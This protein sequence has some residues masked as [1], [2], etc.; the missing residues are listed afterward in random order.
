MPDLKLTSLEILEELQR[1]CVLQE[2]NKVYLIFFLDQI[3]KFLP[4][5][6]CPGLFM[7]TA[8]SQLTL[9]GAWPGAE[10][11]DGFAET[12]AREGSN[13]TAVVCGIE[14]QG[15]GSKNFHGISGSSENFIFTLVHFSSSL[16]VP[17]FSSCHK[18]YLSPETK[19]G[20]RCYQRPQTITL[21]SV[22]S[23][24]RPR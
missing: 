6:Q 20:S 13:L 22:R 11:Q 7:P 24:S 15:F 23:Q 1:K 14:F 17:F 18:I 3:E 16:L 4:Q 2:R 9:V 10:L 21:F 19:I 8:S 5:P 12:L